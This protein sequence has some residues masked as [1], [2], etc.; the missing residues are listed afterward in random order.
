LKK[1]V[2]N[3]ETGEQVRVDLTPDEIAQ[4]E[5]DE[6][7]HNAEKVQRGNRKKDKDVFLNSLTSQERKGFESIVRDRNT[8]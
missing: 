1:L 5:A 4:R 2:V 3:T 6:V 7:R 8:D